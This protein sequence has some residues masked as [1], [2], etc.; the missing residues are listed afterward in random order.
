[1]EEITMIIEVALSVGGFVAGTLATTA[2]VLRRSRRR[3]VN[4]A[5][6]VVLGPELDELITATARN[7][8]A[9]QTNPYAEDVARPWVET[10]VKNAL[11]SHGARP[12][13]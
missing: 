8:A 2:C 9:R 12:R 7:W 1:L 10:F 6:T 3:T 4:V 13:G 5:E 11:R